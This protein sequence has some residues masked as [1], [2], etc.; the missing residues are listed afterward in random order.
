MI[1][2]AGA[3]MLPADYP[4]FARQWVKVSGRVVALFGVIL[5]LM[6]WRPTLQ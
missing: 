4:S 3:D 2:G 1:D 6:I 5:A